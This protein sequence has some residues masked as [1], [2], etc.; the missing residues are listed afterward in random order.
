MGHFYHL[1]MAL[2][3]NNYANHGTGYLSKYFYRDVQFWK[4]LC[5]DMGSWTTFFSEIVQR[6]TNDV[7][8]VDTSGLGCEGV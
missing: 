8:Y 5:A 6:L 7:G 3:A 1:Q 4:Y 2:T